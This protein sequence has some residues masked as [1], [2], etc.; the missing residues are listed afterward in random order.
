MSTVGKVNE[1][2]DADVPRTRS[3]EMARLLLEV[4]FQQRQFRVLDGSF[5]F[6]SL[7]VDFQMTWAAL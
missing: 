4:S 5:K 7:L 3:E 6:Y 1:Q 2:I